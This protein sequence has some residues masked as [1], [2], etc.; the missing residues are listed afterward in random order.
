MKKQILFTLVI[1]FFFCLNTYS[2]M[3]DVDYS[4]HKTIQ[5]NVIYDTLGK[6]KAGDKLEVLGRSFVDL[7][8]NGNMQGTAQILKINIGEPKGF[9]I[10]FYLLVGAS[11][12]GIGS[13]K[14]NEN[15]VSNLLN[16]VGGLLNGTFNGRNN[17][18]ASKSGITSL[19]LSYQISG[20][21]INAQDSI[22]GSS[23]LF[24][25]GYGNFGLFFQTGAWED[26]GE[27]NNM[28]VFWL[29]AKTIASLAFDN[30]TIKEIFGNNISSNY[31]LG[32]AIDLGLEI[33]NR[34]NL[35]AGLYQYLNNQEIELVK[36]PVFKLSLDYNLKNN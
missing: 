36:K 26:Y 28:G 23:K 3:I 6:D 24:G 11:G 9:Y 17:L 35:K 15:T 13:Q 32:Y 34:V 29:Q 21:L 5:K 4:R 22:T 10:P 14:K 12:D 30:A 25:T 7:F 18:Y 19:K 1:M 20:K 2:Q 16:P 8:S 27:K 33:N 31:F